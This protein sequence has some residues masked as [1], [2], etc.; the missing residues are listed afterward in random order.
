MARRAG[1]KRRSW[2]VRAVALLLIVEAAVV[3]ATAAWGLSVRWGEEIT[4]TNVNEGTDQP[5][6][7]EFKTDSPEV[8]AQVGAGLVI[9]LSLVPVLI[10]AVGVLFLLR[11]GWAVA[12]LSQGL[13]IV[14]GLIV[15]IDAKLDLLFPV[16][17]LAIVMVFFLNSQRVRLGFQRRRRAANGVQTAPQ[18]ETP[19]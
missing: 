16:M 8:A 19:A 10:S 4:I 13:I 5:A 3:L 17:A 1:K 18:Q 12:M 11:A 2:P 15:Y 6:Q 14:V 9:A 7:W